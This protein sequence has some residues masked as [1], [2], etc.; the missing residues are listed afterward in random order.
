MPTDIAEEGQSPRKAAAA[1]LPDGV[2][3][4]GLRDSRPV[5]A[6]LRALLAPFG[7]PSDAVFA[8]DGALEPVLQLDYRD[9]IRSKEE[10]PDGVVRIASDT[11]AFVL[12]D[13]ERPIARER[14]RRMRWLLA[15]RDDAPFLVVVTPGRLELYGVDLDRLTADAALLE[16]ITAHEEAASSTFRRLHQEPGG[17]ESARRQAIHDLLYRLLTTAIDGLHALHGIDRADAI[18]LA[19][20]A[21]FMRFLV[22]RGVIGGNRKSPGEICPGAEDWAALFASSEH[23][24]RTSHWIDRTF[25]GDFL[26]VSPG[27]FTRLGDPALEFLRAIMRRS[28]Q[29]RLDFQPVD[30]GLDTP[31][32]WDELDF[33]HIPVGVLSQVY[34]HQA[35]RW[36]PR[37][38]ERDSVYYTP[39]RIAESM[40][41]EA[42][43]RLEAQL[44]APPC[45]AKVLDPAAGG[46]VFLVAAFRELAAAWHRK[47]GAWPSSR[48]LR[49]M[50]FDQL[51][52]FDIQ[53]SA[54]SLTSLSL[55]LT[56]IELDQPPFRFEDLRFDR[57]LRGHVLFALGGPATADDDSVAGSL[58]PRAPAGHDQRYDLV[59]ANPPWTSL[60]GKAGKRVMAEA[61]AQLRPIVEA[62]LGAERARAF[63]IPD[64]VPDLPFVWRAM[65]WA[66]P[67][68]VLAFALHGRLL[69]KASALGTQARVDLFDAV[70]TWGVLNGADLQT[71]AVWPAILQ[72]FCLLFADNALPPADHVFYVSSPYYEPGLNKS[73]RLRIDPEALQPISPARLKQL[74]SLLKALFRGTA[75]DVHILERLVGRAW[76]TLAAYWTRQRLASGDGFQKT[77]QEQDASHLLGLPLLTAGQ[78][79][80]LEIDASRLPRFERAR[81]HRARNPAIYRGPQLVL[82]ESV[83][84][85]H[86]HRAHVSAAGVVFSESFYGYSAH[87]H[88]DGLRLVRY[89][90]LLFHSSL[91]AWY[92]LVTGGKFGVERPVWNKEDVAGFPVVP[93]EDLTGAQVEALDQHFAAL[94]ADALPRER[95]D[96][97]VVDLYGLGAPAARV[98][99]DTLKVGLPHL[100]NQRFAAG[101]PEDAMVAAFAGQLAER[102]AP[103][104]R[105]DVQV[106]PTPPVDPYRVLRIGPDPTSARHPDIAR[107]LELAD[108]F[109]S[110]EFIMTDDRGRL[111]LGRLAQ[112]RYWTLSR[113]RLTA[114]R[115][116]EE[117]PHLGRDG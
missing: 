19:G 109:G 35:E 64:Q 117:H 116:L 105:V 56:A 57:P 94:A 45:E 76:P 115:L 65:R 13:P 24:R 51:A 12:C 37:G 100:D 40:V 81:V 32:T 111:W 85:T 23:Y 91:F 93:L 99:A 8:F 31:F 4:P 103:F 52:G 98:M 112:R 28:A 95:L 90:C 114:A 80:G 15:Q 74:P 96:A 97:W 107:V 22:D 92:N 33:A 21:L 47:T 18:A 72:P 63:G 113:A 53:E 26:P 9:L 49:I 110:S 30:L 78:P 77:S 73:G 62:R 44:G 84:F 61:L 25:N 43:A 3:D 89:L 41:R 39:R 58:G 86:A 2:P 108:T 16:T 29:T 70:T 34:E 75:L 54:L 69:F 1:S 68:G 88:P 7:A 102:L 60:P 101:A 14:I 46:G 82:R 83:Q 10:R 87:G 48:R 55:Y 20:R 106:I 42:F 5:S 71:T 67:G 104:A 11:V 79:I 17:R 59:I 38:R 6:S 27:A 50:L 66:R 36:D